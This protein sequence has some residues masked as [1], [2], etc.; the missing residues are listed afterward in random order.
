MSIVP[1]RNYRYIIWNTFSHSWSNDSGDMDVPGRYPRSMDIRGDQGVALA[2][3]AGERKPF[4]YPR[5][6]A[7]NSR[8]APKGIDI[9]AGPGY[10]TYTPVGQY[11]DG[12][13]S[14]VNERAHL[15]SDLARRVA[16]IEGQLKGIDRLLRTEDVTQAITQCSAARNALES[17]VKVVLHASITGRFAMESSDETPERVFKHA[18]ERAMTHWFFPNGGETRLDPTLLEPG[19]KNVAGRHISAIQDRLKNIGYALAGDD[20]LSALPE[21]GAMIREIDELMSLALC[22]FVKARMEGK[23]GGKK[24]RDTFEQSV[25]QALKYWRIPDLHVVESVRAEQ[26]CKILVVDDDPDIVTY[27]KHILQKRSYVV[28]T[29]S[30]A[31]EAMRRVETERPALIILDVMMPSGIEGFQFTWSLR[32]RPEAEL[33]KIPIIVLSA[34]HQTTTLR[35]YPDQKDGYYGPGEYLPVE[36]F[37][38]K[39]VEEEAFLRQVEWALRRAAATVGAAQTVKRRSMRSEDTV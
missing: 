15:A 12:R 10:S 34:I 23:R 28:T 38:D 26:G 36:A 6:G 24:A 35:L 18:L 13:G 21:L 5:V 27:L 33:R 30:N 8:A 31:E 19:L 25:A 17:L 4:F 39:P 20:Y 1:A 32:S 22:E 2:F 3:Y 29:A 9:T 14:F 7:K 11:G 37:M 16:T